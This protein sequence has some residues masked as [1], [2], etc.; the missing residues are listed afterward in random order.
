MGLINTSHL[1]KFATGFEEKAREL[2]AK[3]T[4]IPESLPANGGNA[5]TV[6]GHLLRQKERRG[7]FLN[8]GKGSRIFFYEVMGHGESLRKRQMKISMR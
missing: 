1:K 8:R 5:S 7:L 2:F 3:K 4:D 6:N